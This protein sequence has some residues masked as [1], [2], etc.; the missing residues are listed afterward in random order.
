MGGARLIVPTEEALEAFIDS[1]AH[2]EKVFEAYLKHID[3]ST[4]KDVANN[5]GSDLSR[6]PEIR[7]RIE[8]RRKELV[9]DSFDDDAIGAEEPVT[10]ERLIRDCEFVMRKAKICVAR[11]VDGI[12][13]INKSAADILLRAIEVNAKLIGAYDNTEKVDSTVVVQLSKEV[14]DLAK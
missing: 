7:E 13:I 1:V 11:N 10:K 8:R 5:R 12:G 9:L 6:K 2:G 3:G 4:T 14:K